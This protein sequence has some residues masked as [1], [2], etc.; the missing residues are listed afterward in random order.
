MITGP[1][2]E[3]FG[4]VVDQKALDF[5]VALDGEFAHA[6]G[7]GARHPSRPAGALRGGSAAGIPARDAGDPRGPVVAGGAAGTRAGRPAG[8]DHRADG[9]AR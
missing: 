5:L 6:A 3:R 7:P 8:R 2:E 9:P 1:M 4:E